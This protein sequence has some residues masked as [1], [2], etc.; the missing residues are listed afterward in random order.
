MSLGCTHR[1][2]SDARQNEEEADGQH[3]EDQDNG[4]QAAAEDEGGPL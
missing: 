4:E 3:Q 1:L 2:P